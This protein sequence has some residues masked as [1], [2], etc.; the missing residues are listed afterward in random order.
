[1]QISKKEVSITAHKAALSKIVKLKEQTKEL[2]GECRRLRKRNKA[3]E[4]SRT[5]WREKAKERI[6]EVN[7]LNN[8][9]LHLRSL[10]SN[11]KIKWHQYSLS[12]INLVV[13]LRIKGKCSYA[14]IRKVLGI[15]YFYLLDL[16]EERVRLPSEKTMQNWVSKLG[17]YELNEIDNQLVNKDVCL[18]IDESVFVGNESL[19]LCLICPSFRTI[20]EKEKP[21][22]YEDMKVLC[23]KGAKSWTGEQISDY[24]RPILAEKGYNLKYVVSDEGN[25]L[26]KSTRLLETPHLFDISHAIATCLK[27]TFSKQEAYQ[28]FTKDVR[29]YQSKLSTGKYSYLRPPKQRAKARFMNQSNL[30]DWATQILSKWDSFD[31][32]SKIIFKN[33]I[34]HESIIL[35]LRNCIDIAKKIANCLKTKGLNRKTIEET[36]AIESENKEMGQIFLKYLKPYLEKYRE[37]INKEE[38][39]NK[40]LVVCSDIIE[41][42]FGYYK[43]KRSD[44]YFAGLTTLCL[45]LPLITLSK[46]ALIEKTKEVFEEVKMTDLIQWKKEHSSDNQS[47]KRA[48]FNQN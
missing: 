31:E 15:L 30:V 17:Y 33:M 12:L 5:N 44:N 43:S 36:L 2:R 41:S 48:E 25:N 10:H 18:I 32:P 9:L 22:T 8:K 1:M 40:T 24:V 21:L 45:E 38:W 16:K 26:K 28:D 6:I 27:K 37:F 20:K 19:L 4:K 39:N 34:K 35:K 14:S 47:L 29:W 7:L 13:L 11:N 46:E 42:F 3:L 23:M